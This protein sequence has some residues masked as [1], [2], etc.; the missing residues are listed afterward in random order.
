MTESEATPTP[1]WPDNPAKRDLVGFSDIAAPA[2]EALIGRSSTRVTDG[3]VGW[4]IG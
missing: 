3:V 4:C 1:L 2:L